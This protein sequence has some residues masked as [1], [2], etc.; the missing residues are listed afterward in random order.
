[1]KNIKEVITEFKGRINAEIRR[2]E[3]LNIV[4]ER[5]FRR[6]ELLE[7]YIVKILFRWNN[8]KFKDKYLKKMERN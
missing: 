1:M 5:D 6:K 3:K 8:K 4:K 7:K 2:Q